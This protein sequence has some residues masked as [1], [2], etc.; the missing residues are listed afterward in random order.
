MP[1][2]GPAEGLGVGGLSLK[3]MMGQLGMSSSSGVPHSVTSL[4]VPSAREVNV[5]AESKTNNLEAELLQGLSQSKRDRY[6]DMDPVT[7]AR[8]LNK[9]YIVRQLKEMFRRKGVPIHLFT[10][11]CRAATKEVFDKFETK[12]AGGYLNVK[13]FMVLEGHHVRHIVDK[14]MKTHM[15]DKR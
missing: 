6:A 13:D 3:S 12:R 1:G 10:Q 2:G 8:A 11:I 4:G 15:P 14:V 9:E 7:K 5:S